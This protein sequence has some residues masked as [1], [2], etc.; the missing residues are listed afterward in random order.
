MNLH[1][2]IGMS[3]Y[4]KS[5]CH[6]DDYIRCRFHDI[7][8]NTTRREPQDPPSYSDTTFGCTLSLPSQLLEFPAHGECP[9]ENVCGLLVSNP[10]IKFPYLPS[11]DIH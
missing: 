2:E 9:I 8:T 7:N 5:G 4:S 11:I 1:I 10:C 3:A 6:Y